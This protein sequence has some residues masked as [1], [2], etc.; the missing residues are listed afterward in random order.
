MLPFLL[1]LRSCLAVGLRLNT[2]TYNTYSQ[3]LNRPVWLLQATLSSQEER[4]TG[5]KLSKEKHVAD[6]CQLVSSIKN[7]TAIPRTHGKRSKDEFA[8]SQARHQDESEQ[9]SL[10]QNSNYSSDTA[11]ASCASQATTHPVSNCPEDTSTTAF[12]S[13]VIS[14]IPYVLCRQLE[15]GSPSTEEQTEQRTHNSG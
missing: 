7:R 1:R 15:G 2:D 3:R 11:N 6:I 12:R 9:N 13:T 10:H 5:G 8:A 4:P 14:N